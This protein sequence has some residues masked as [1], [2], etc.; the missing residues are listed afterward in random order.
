ME[1]SPL[2]TKRLICYA[3]PALVAGLLG[4]LISP[5]AAVLCGGLALLAVGADL[6]TTG[7]RIQA[8]ADQE[9]GDR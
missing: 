5:A 9:G 4:A 1:G 6:Y 3:L 2:S 7:R 8:E